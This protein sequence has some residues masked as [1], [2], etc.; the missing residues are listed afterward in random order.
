MAKECQGQPMGMGP[1]GFDPSVRF[2]RKFRWTFEIIDICGKGKTNSP[3]TSRANNS[4]TEF[5]KGVSGRIPASFVK[6]ASR[7]NLTIDEIEINYLNG[8]TWIPGK[9]TWETIT[10]TYYDISDDSAAAKPLWDW[11]AT[12]Y[13]FTD[14][15][16]LN[17][18]SARNN[19]SGTGILKLYDGCG[20]TLETWTLKDCWP[21]AINFGDLDY[22]AS[23]EVV[24][25][26]TL[27]YSQVQYDP[28][29][30]S[31]VIEPCCDPCN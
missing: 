31:F 16:C 11:L 7:P 19:Y 20:S 10:V 13:N 8:K 27:R 5:S 21:Q 6:L 12:V 3:T 30:H 14:P 25:E 9:G 1:I 22:S 26:L 17:Q 4:P 15:V 29:C 24:I 18:A 28:G 2:K 23:E